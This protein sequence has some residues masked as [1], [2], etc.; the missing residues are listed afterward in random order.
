MEL[1]CFNHFSRLFH[2]VCHESIDNPK[3]LKLRPE[4]IEIYMKKYIL[5]SCIDIDERYLIKNG[6]TYIPSPAFIKWATPIDH[7]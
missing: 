1:R 2:L 3:I 4:V 5:S 6:D 7:D